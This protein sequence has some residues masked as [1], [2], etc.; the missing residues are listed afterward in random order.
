METSTA[1]IAVCNHKGGCGKTTTVVNLAYEIARTGLSVLIVD[2][3]PQANLSLHIGKQ[4]PS[5][6][7]VTSAELLLGDVSTL[8]TAIHEDTYLPG[9]SLIY[10]SLNLDKVED[11]LWDVATRPYEELR[12]KL[13]PLKGLYDVILLDCRPNIKL[14]TSNALAAA[15]HLIIP[16]ESGSQYSLY[17]AADL[18][19][20]ITK[21]RTVNPELQLLGVLLTRHDARQTACALIA[22]LATNTFGSVLPVTVGTSAAKINQAVI[23]QKA[24]YM[25]D[26]KAKIAK[27]YRRLARHVISAVGL[28]S[29]ADLSG[30]IDES[31]TEDV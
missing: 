26:P 19:K 30:D 25:Q 31:E 8:A 22:T 4:H 23:N 11:D 1:I 14:L 20:H 17:G 10:G 16:I 29:K 2:L 9:V 3:D 15:T 28:A 27:E 5:E 6:I 12:A 24:I 13:E 7:S 18:T 21:M